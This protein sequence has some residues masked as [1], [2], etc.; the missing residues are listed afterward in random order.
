MCAHFVI[1]LTQ[2]PTLLHVLHMLLVSLD[3]SSSW[4]IKCKLLLGTQTFPL[5]SSDS[6]SAALRGILCWWGL[7][8]GLCCCVLAGYTVTLLPWWFRCVSEPAGDLSSVVMSTVKHQSAGHGLSITLRVA[9]LAKGDYISGWDHTASSPRL[10]CSLAL[11]PSLFPFTYL[12]LSLW[13]PPLC[14]TVI[15]VIRQALTHTSRKGET[16]PR[17]ELARLLSGF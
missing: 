3:N 13:L 9:L 12:S 4:N 6:A 7:S 5:T 17:C 1:V 15:V 8:M 10:E 11:S 2:E 14:L 16:L